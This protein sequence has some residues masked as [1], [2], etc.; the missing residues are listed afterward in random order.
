MSV[1]EKC[2]SGKGWK[3]QYYKSK[4]GEL[5]DF[6]IPY[7]C[8]SIM[9]YH[10]MS[11]DPQCPILTP[12]KGLNCKD[13]IVGGQ[14]AELLDEDWLMIYIAHCCKLTNKYKNCWKWKKLGKCNTQTKWDKWMG[15]NCAQSCNCTSAS[16]ETFRKNK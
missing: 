2:I 15:E 9:H 16:H 6:G 12:K 10:E 13:G 5:E 4:E 1:N 11:K 3:A 7:M 8:Q 14:S